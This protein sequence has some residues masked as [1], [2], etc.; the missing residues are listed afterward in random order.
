ML[1]KYIAFY[2]GLKDGRVAKGDN[3]FNR[4]FRS[5]SAHQAKEFPAECGVSI[6]L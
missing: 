2:L 5:C 1:A 3:F 6:R 4:F